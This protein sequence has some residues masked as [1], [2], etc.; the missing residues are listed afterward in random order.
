MPLA[1]SMDAPVP[2]TSGDGYS[3]S[4]RTRSPDLGGA[5]R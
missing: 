1:M 5:A 2:L 4:P 3:P